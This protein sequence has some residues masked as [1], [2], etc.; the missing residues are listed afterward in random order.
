MKLRENSDQGAA[1]K[2]NQIIN[3]FMNEHSELV[4]DNK[5]VSWACKLGIRLTHNG[6]LDESQLFHLFVLAVLWNSK[7]TYQA[8]RG[9]RVFRD[10]KDTY[11]LSNFRKA[12][13]D[14][15]TREQ[16]MD[17][18]REKITNSSV[19]N[20]LDFIV[21]GEID[22]NSVWGRIREILNSRN[23]GNEIYDVNRLKQLYFIFNPEKRRRHYEGD[24]YLTKKTFLVFRELRI[25]FRELERYQY[26]PSICCVPDSHVEES[27][28]NILGILIKSKKYET[29]KVEW[30]LKISRKVAECFCRTP[31]E[32]YD[33]PLFYAH[34]ESA[35]GQLNQ[36]PR[37]GMYAGKCPMCGSP[38]VWRKARQ[39]A[40]LYRGC[41]NF[42]GGC[43]WQDRSY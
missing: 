43:R 37:R 35:Y 31:Y 19:F 39:T 27:I 41:T 16:L 7:P 23:V 22:N 15:E 3:W 33:L 14:D 24:A 25:Q 17:I 10:I 20:I 18:A 40:E 13:H 2:C 29:E 5:L 28:T 21:N 32:L 30:L 8:E 1:G 36:Q 42:K 11:T 12:S 38:L 34:K 9:E 26:H 4:E 6:K